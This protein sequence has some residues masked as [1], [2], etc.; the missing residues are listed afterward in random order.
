M[1]TTYKVLGQAAPA[2]TTETP[3]YTVPTLKSAVVSSITVANRSNSAIAYFRIS[4]SVGGAVT[5]D[6]DYL[7]YGVIIGQSDTFIA[8]VGLTLSAGD[9]IRVYA[10]TGNLTFQAFGTEIS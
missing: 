5:T 1:A 2:L 4:V 6:Q 3:L 10:T 7:Y 9:V 8:T